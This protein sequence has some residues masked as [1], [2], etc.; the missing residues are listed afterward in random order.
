MCS[1]LSQN[2]FSYIKNSEGDMF[3]YGRA[4]KECIFLLLTVY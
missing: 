4:E 3:I 1:F 2:V